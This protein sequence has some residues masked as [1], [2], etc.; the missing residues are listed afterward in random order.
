MSFTIEGEKKTKTIFADVTFLNFYILNNKKLLILQNSYSYWANISKFIPKLLSEIIRKSENS[1]Q[2][3]TQKIDVKERIS[4][5]VKGS[6]PFNCF[7]NVL[8]AF[9][10]SV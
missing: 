3:A 9:Q 1:C 4:R 2:E 8:M 5:G 10:T 6:T 7:F